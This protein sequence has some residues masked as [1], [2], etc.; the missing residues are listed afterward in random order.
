M[1]WIG[2]AVFG[3]K[4]LFIEIT[5]FISKISFPKKKAITLLVLVEQ[6]PIQVPP[7]FFKKK[8][9]LCLLI[10]CVYTCVYTCVHRIDTYKY[11]GSST[12]VRGQPA[13]VS[14]SFHNGSQDPFRLSGWAANSLT[15]WASHQWLP[16]SV[17]RVSFFTAYLEELKPFL[18]RVTVLKMCYN[19]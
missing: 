2:K 17:L 16:F 4:L 10:I 12:E 5:W 11:Y 9:F 1:N 13:I 18:L 8:M 6:D 14:F 15:Y 3:N 19:L 7:P